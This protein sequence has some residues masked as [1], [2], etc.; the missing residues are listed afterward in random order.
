M[1]Q[2]NRS[3]LCDILSF[4]LNYPQFG[5]FDVEEIE[6]LLDLKPGDVSLILRP[7]HSVLNFRR[8]VAVHH[9]S[10]RDFL[11]HEKRSSLFYVG[12]FQHCAKL[13]CSILKVLRYTYHELQN[14]QH[15]LW[16]HV[17]SMGPGIAPLI[18]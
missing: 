13:A 4:I 16:R 2:R 10:F 11:N 7:L 14:N 15:N 12:S 1:P 8:K 3:G 6:E 5:D 9:A 17:Q 18:F